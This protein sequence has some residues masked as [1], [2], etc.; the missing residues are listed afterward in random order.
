MKQRRRLVD[1]WASMSQAE[2]DSYHGR[3]VER[4]D[5][6]ASNPPQLR[7]ASS[8]D[9]DSLGHIRRGFVNLI[10]PQPLDVRNR[11]LWTKMCILLYKLDTE[12]YEHS[13]GSEAVVVMQPTPF[14]AGTPLA[15]ETF[16][17]HCFVETADFDA[18]AMTLDGFVVFHSADRAVLFADQ[19]SLDTG[20][21]LLCDIEGNGQLRASSRMW[22]LWTYMAYCYVYGLGWYGDRVIRDYAYAD[23]DC[24]DN[25]ALDMELPILELLQAKKQYF[26]YPEDVNIDA[27]KKAIEHY[28]PGYLEMEAAGNGM[29]PDYDHA[30]LML[31]C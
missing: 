10:V 16:Y 31:D 11:A 3:A 1:Q 26:E 24:E 9:D 25:A 15:P 6:R 17:R 19:E 28:A 27:W 21:L 12:V 18:M 7:D 2:R 29:A 8:K 22:P 14:H 20:R 13:F 4:K 5:I 23:G 30:N